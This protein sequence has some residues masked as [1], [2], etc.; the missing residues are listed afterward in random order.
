M[1][2]NT[3]DYSAV[4]NNAKTSGIQNSINKV[5]TEDTTDE[6]M[7][8]AC[9]EFEAYM[10]EQMFKQ[11]MNNIRSDEEDSSGYADFAYDLQAQQYA[12]M[13]SDSGDLGLA[14]QLY[15][16]MK[17]NQG[18]KNIT[19]E[20]ETDNTPADVIENIATAR[21]TEEIEK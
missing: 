8:N 18:V 9:K 3:T 15:E 1:D 14:R 6:E 10:V 19:T 4:I 17:R 11:A 13:V 21:K 20:E 16:S 2:I 12:K 7:I 5:R